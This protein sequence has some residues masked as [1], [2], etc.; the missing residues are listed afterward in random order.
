M[1]IA[2]VVGA[3]GLIGNHLTKKLLN[4]EHYDLV[5]IFTR[6]SLNIID[7]KLEEN[8]VDFNKIETWKEKIKG[9][10]LFSSLGTTIKK[11]G[12]REAQYKIDFTYQYDIAKWG[13]ENGVE[14]Y[15]L[16]SSGGADSKSKNF[17]LRTKGELEEK[18][19]QLKF[20]NLIIFQPSLLLGEREEK[21]VGETIGAVLAK[22]VI[23]LLPFLKKYRPIEGAVVAAAMINSVQHSSLKR[24]QRYAYDQIFTL[25]EK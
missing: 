22:G 7:P 23:P 16:V 1:K 8:I 17:Y 4:D 13:P 3:T 20:E 5:R 19:E 12:S 24:I 18:V 9:N 2:L 25:I 15:V 11:A 10:V 6:R 21:R 14:K